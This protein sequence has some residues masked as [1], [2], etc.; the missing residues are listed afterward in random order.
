MGWF[1]KKKEVNLNTDM[2]ELP[3]LPELPPLPDLNQAS[4]GL[5]ELPRTEIKSLPSFP[6]SQTG[7]AFSQEV[8]KSAISPP[9]SKNFGVP[10]TG[11]RTL[12]ISELPEPKFSQQKTELQPSLMAHH[13]SPVS[14]FKQVTRKIEP[15]YIRLDKFKS[16]TESFEEIKSKTSEIEEILKAIRETKQREEQ[17]L[18]EWEQELETIKARIDAIDKNIFSR[19]D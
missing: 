8:I 17:E 16:A 12:E 14:N 5:P 6:T 7:D 2:P 1:K 9:T 13:T 3:E 4:L 11:K 15:V 18:R 10:R 19:L